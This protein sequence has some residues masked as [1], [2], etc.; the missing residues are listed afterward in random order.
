MLFDMESDS[1]ELHDLGDRPEHAE[2]IETMYERLGAWA[3]RPSQRTT[4]SETQLV[5]GRGKGRRKGIVQGLYDG[6]EIEAELLTKYRGV[7]HERYVG[8]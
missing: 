2:A 4:M 5:A 8:S 1:Q 6:S 3:R 7:A